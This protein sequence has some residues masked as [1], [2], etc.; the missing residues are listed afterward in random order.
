M[1]LNRL[2]QDIFKILLFFL[3]ILTFAGLNSCATGPMQ[4][5]PEDRI[6]LTPDKPQQGTWQSQFAILEYEVVKQNG[7]VGLIIDGRTTR[8]LEQIVVWL[9]FLD[10]KGK[11]IERETVFNSGFRTQRTRARRMQGTIERAFEVPKGAKYV[12]FQAIKQPY[13]GS[14]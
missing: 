13:R 9:L 14:Q 7:Y 2:G 5:A 4:V 11:L 8:T 6:L 3:V 1:K 12:A 10:E